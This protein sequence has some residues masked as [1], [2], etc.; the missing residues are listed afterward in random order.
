MADTPLTIDVI[1]GRMDTPEQAERIKKLYKQLQ[2]IGQDWN[3]ISPA[4]AFKI[5]QDK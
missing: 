3:I 4:P 5:T 1:I 2:K